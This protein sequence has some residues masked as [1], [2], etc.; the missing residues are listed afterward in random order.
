MKKKKWKGITENEVYMG[1]FDFSVIVLVG[2]YKTALAYVSWKFE[3]KTTDLGAFD[4]EYV[5]RGKCFFRQGYVPVIWIPRKPK[6]PREHATLSHESLHAV[7][8]LFEWAGLPITRDTEEVM[9]HAMS[10]IITNAIK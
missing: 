5:P 7:F 2:D 6:T 4:M 1:T 3:D 8:H 9:T 10:H